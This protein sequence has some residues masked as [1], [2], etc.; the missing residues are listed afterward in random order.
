MRNII[1]VIG[2][3]LGLGACGSGDK[4]RENQD[5][6]TNLEQTGND[7]RNMADTLGTNA[8]SADSAATDTINQ[9]K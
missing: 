7:N 6:T 8:A 5:T 9:K 2:L 4:A 1:I 3:L